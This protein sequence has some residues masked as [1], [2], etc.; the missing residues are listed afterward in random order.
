M[1]PKSTSFARRV[2]LGRNTFVA[3]DPAPPADPADILRRYS[4]SIPVDVAEVARELGVRVFLDAD[5]PAGIIGRL[6][7]NDRGRYDIHV[8]KKQI[9]ERKRVIVAHELGHYIFHRSLVGEGVEDDIEY[10][11]PQGGLFANDRIRPFHEAQANSFAA[12]LLVPPER[13]QEKAEAMN[14]DVATASDD[15]VER[16]AEQFAV[17]RPVMRWRLERLA[18]TAAPNLGF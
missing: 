9:P 14:I 6:A 18:A 17:P 5:L 1:A 8:D 4:N 15:E 3:A 16:L 2:F 11:S 10:R 12:A 13:V 7:R